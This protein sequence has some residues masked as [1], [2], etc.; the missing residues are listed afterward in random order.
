MEAYFIWRADQDFA[1]EIPESTRTQIEQDIKTCRPLELG[2]GE[3]D[4]YG[5]YWG[6]FVRESVDAERVREAFENAGVNYE[7][8][9]WDWQT[10]N[11]WDDVE[12]VMKNRYEAVK[13]FSTSQALPTTFK[14]RELQENSGGD[15]GHIKFPSDATNQQIE[16]TFYSLN[17]S[18]GLALTSLHSNGRRSTVYATADAVVEDVDVVDSNGGYELQVTLG[19]S[20]FEQYLNNLPDSTASV[21]LQTPGAALPAFDMDDVEEGSVVATDLRARYW[22]SF[23]SATALLHPLP[24]PVFANFPAATCGDGE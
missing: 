21:Q 13:G 18:R 20:Q 10:P 14:M 9:W 22:E 3:D 16:R 4:G 5:P 19:G 15:S 12:V 24:D 7:G 17:N 6:Y 8:E 1:A 11:N 2:R 23:G